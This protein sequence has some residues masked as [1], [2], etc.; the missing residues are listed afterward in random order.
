[1][2]PVVE[3]IGCALNAAVHAQDDAAR[4][5]GRGAQMK[6]ASVAPEL[7]LGAYVA[8]SAG[9]PTD[10]RALAQFGAHRGA[11]RP[12]CSCLRGI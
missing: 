6:S 4:A 1:M 8:V 10:W 7:H 2:A 3:S 9:Y 12:I 5:V 11:V